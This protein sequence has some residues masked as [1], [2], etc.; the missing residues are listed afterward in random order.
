VAPQIVVQQLDAAW[1]FVGDQPQVVGDG[2]EFRRRILPAGDH[3]NLGL[4]VGERQELAGPL[5][6]LE[7][8]RR[9]RGGEQFARARKP[10]RRAGPTTR[11]T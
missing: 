1:W 9:E 8:A 3:V 5:D 4:L 10:G 6:V 11:R 2:G 7:Q